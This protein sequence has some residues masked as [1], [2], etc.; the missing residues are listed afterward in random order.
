[1]GS[2]SALL[3][4][5]RV[6]LKYH[7]LCRV[8]CWGKLAC[9]RYLGILLLLLPL[10]VLQPQAAIM[11][12]RRERCGRCSGTFQSPPPLS[13]CS[14]CVYCWHRP[15]EVPRCV[16]PVCAQRPSGGTSAFLPSCVTIAE[17]FSC[18][19]CHRPRSSLSPHLCTCS[20]VPPHHVRSCEVC[21][22]GRGEATCSRA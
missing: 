17:Y 11:D 4:I 22:E 9:C 3:H 8:I 5:S 14:Y 6:H 19:S 2:F 20:C 15:C 7:W 10:A 12:V 13:T 1:V 21:F 18:C 16:E